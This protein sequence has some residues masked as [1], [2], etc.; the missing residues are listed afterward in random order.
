M[1]NRF[2]VIM[3]AMLA[4][5]AFPNCLMAQ[6]NRGEAIAQINSSQ[7]LLA[8][9]KDQYAANQFTKAIQLFQQA[10]KVSQTQKAL[11]LIPASK[12]NSVETV[13]TLAWLGDAALN[14][15]NDEK[16]LEII[17]RAIAL[18]KKISVPLIDQGETVH[19]LG[20]AYSRNG[21][22]P[23][24][25]ETFNQALV[26][27]Q[28]SSDRF[29][30]VR[31]LNSIAGVY[32][33]QQNFSKA[34]EFAERGLK[35][36]QE[37]KNQLGVATSLYNTGYVYG[38]IDQVPKSLKILQQ[39]LA[40][41]EGLG[42]RL[43][44][45]DVLNQISNI[46]AVGFQ[47]T[48]GLK[49]DLMAL[50]IFREYGDQRFIQYALEEIAS[51]YANLTQYPKALDFYK[52]ALKAA[53][54]ITDPELNDRIGK[55]NILYRMAEIYGTQGQH[56]EAIATYEKAAGI[57][58]TAL[59]L[60]NPRPRSKGILAGIYQG[61]GESEGSLSQYPQAIKAMEKWAIAEGK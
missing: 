55:G 32:T 12:A 60:P 59:A 56:R 51:T 46:N 10:L 44:V 35:L 3:A 37:A 42:D 11:K 4:T 34:L 57:Y 9:G 26:I 25:L 47:F 43:S 45:G 40:V 36:N 19:N 53:D 5:S 39:S 38:V 17:E 8:Q 29:N 54:Q 7:T 58:V 50:D 16:G 15:G 52:Q 48:E 30:E 13:R 33:Q 2:S 18:T 1:N 41:Y 24:A 28:K 14:L 21:R 49:L 61:L 6:E 23:Q 27:R 31:A 22:Y 20:R